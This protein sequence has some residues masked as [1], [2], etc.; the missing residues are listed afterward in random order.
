VAS[1]RSDQQEPIEDRVDLGDLHL[2][3]LRWKD[4]GPRPALLLI[5]P[6]ATTADVWSPYMRVTC[7]DRLAVAV[8]LRGHGGSSWSTLGND[9]DTWADD[10][11]RV[12]E[13][14]DLGPVVVIASA[15]GGAAALLLASRWPQHVAAVVANDVGYDIPTEVQEQVQSRLREGHRAPDAATALA[16]YHAA[17]WFG[18]EQRSWF[19]E[20][21]LRSDGREVVW[22]YDPVGVPKVMDPRERPFLEDLAVRCPTL[23]L[24]GS[25][26]GPLTPGAFER[27][28]AAI[29]HA[30]SATIPRSDHIPS[31]DAT[32]AYAALVD[33]F[34]N[35]RTPSRTEH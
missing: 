29:P 22:R 9:I 5:H 10:L 33:D 8:D 32:A 6:N 20:T 15:L 21:M 14:L 3:Y 11:R 30:E 25:D 35:R 12:I 2:R 28:I 27:L 26:S 1:T 19:A 4:D 31:V 18:P 24:R 34:V 16:H 23:L 13:T 7:L 17:T